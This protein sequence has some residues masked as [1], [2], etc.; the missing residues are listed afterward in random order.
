MIKK[1]ALFAGLCLALLLSTSVDAREVISMNA[2]WNFTPTRSAGG[3][4]WE[5]SAVEA[6]TS[7]WSIFLTPGT[8]RTL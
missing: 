8:Q 6:A 7:R 4:R 5:V 3:G 2:E 1:T